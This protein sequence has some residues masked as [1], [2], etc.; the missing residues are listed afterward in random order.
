MVIE[1]AQAS[2]LPAVKRLLQA[3]QLPLDGVDEHVAT[4][5]V[6]RRAG[7]VVGAAAVEMYAD[8][9]LLRSVVV[10]AAV[11]ALLPLLMGR[12]RRRSRQ[13]E[14]VGA[15]TPTPRLILTSSPWPLRGLSLPIKRGMDSRLRPL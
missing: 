2:D 3:G 1:P 8:G 13:G 7:E 11:R 5:V 14:G 10:D 12:D 9:A 6:A 15:G 4:M